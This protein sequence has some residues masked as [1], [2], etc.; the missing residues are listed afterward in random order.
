MTI[1]TQVNSIIATTAAP[2]RKLIRVMAFP[3][4]SRVCNIGNLFMMR[5]K[6]T[7]RGSLSGISLQFRL[8]TGCRHQ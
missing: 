6:K 4:V 3:I 5:K 2:A 8:G 1:S 7:F